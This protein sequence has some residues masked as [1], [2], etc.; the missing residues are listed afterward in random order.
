MD[1]AKRP[2]SISDSELILAWR[3]CPSAQKASQVE[4]EVSADEHKTW[5]SSRVERIK[6]EPF[7]IMSRGGEETGYVRLD[8]LESGSNVFTLSIYVVPQSRGMGVGRVM[9]RVAVEA[10]AKD[11]AVTHFRAVIKKSNQASIKLFEFVGFKFAG[12]IDKNFG[13]YLLAAN[14][15]K[16]NA[17]NF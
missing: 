2:I 9:L 6:F 4:G 14:K 5:F 16:S 7:W 10:A 8:R 17:F 13:E 12:D 11:Y 1:I 15:I 3:N